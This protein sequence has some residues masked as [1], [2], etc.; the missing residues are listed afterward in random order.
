[1]PDRILT[2]EQLIKELEKYDHKELHVHHTWKPDHSD[3]A[4]KPDGL[5]WNQAIRN[6]HIN[7][8]GWSDIGQHV[9]LCP[10]GKFVTGR[11][12]GKTPA[13]IEGYNIGAFTVEMIGN[14]DIGHDKFEGPQKEAM[15]GLAR[16][17]YRRGKYIRFHRENAPKTCP[18]SSIDKNVFMAE[19]RGQIIERG[20]DRV[21]LKVG[22]KGN[23][24]KALQEKLNSLGFNCGAADG[25][26]GPKTEAAVKAFQQAHGLTVDGIAGP[27]T[28]AK[29]EEL[30]NKPT[31]DAEIKRLKER[32]KELELAVQNANTKVIIAERA[33]QEAESKLKRYEEFFRTFREFLGGV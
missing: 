24:V 28:L 13:S 3:W 26:F 11:D 30:L 22:V 27:Q 5:Y 10:D 6:Y 1:M 9:T 19:V 33:A 14:F 7:S 4:K 2:L 25:I 20:D 17:F 23:E 16:W 31:N 32:I 12:F 8:R 29:I 15:I 21:L 18:G